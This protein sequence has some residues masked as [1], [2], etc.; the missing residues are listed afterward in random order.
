MWLFLFGV[1]GDWECEGF[2]YLVC[3]GEGSVL[4]FVVFFFCGGWEWVGLVVVVFIFRILVV[5]V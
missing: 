4:F 1:C 5:V 2:W 3:G